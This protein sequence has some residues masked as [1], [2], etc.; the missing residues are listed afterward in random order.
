[1]K[2]AIIT[3][4]SSG[5]GREFARQLDREGL[6]QLWLIA[7]RGELLEQLQSE[8]STACRL[9]PMDLKNQDEIESLRPLLESERPNISMLVNN[10][11]FGK[12]GDF[13]DAPL[14]HQLGMV[15]VNVSALVHITHLA[16]PFMSRGSTLIHISSISGFAP[17]GAFNVYAASKAF[18]TFFSIALVSE[19]K[20]RGI[21]SLAVCPGPVETEFGKKS[22][23]GSGRQKKMFTKKAD[24]AAVVAKALRDARKKKTYSIYGLKANLIH[25]LVR[26]LP[27]RKAAEIAYNSVYKKFEPEDF[28]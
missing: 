23:K 17:L 14:K 7:R 11:G 21:H 15:E 5:I 18:V 12:M 25:L 26:F 13:A 19:L 4:A 2:I 20:E 1:M 8:L 22:A 3:G 16:L 10:A 24:P 28:S 9:F 27:K 6:D